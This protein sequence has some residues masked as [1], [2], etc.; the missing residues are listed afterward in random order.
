MLEPPLPF[1]VLGPSSRL[2]IKFCSGTH[3]NFEE[4]C[5]HLNCCGSQEFPFI[6]CNYAGCKESHEHVLLECVMYCMN[7]TDKLFL[8]IYMKQIITAGAFKAFNY[9]SIFDKA[10]L[11]LGKNKVC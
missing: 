2:F 11:C 8:P 5:G 1:R 10:V 7:P 3:G 9:S 4:F 6:R